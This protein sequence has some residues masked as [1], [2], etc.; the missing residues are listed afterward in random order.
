MRFWNRLLRV[1]KEVAINGKQK[2]TQNKKG[3]KNSVAGNRKRSRFEICEK[4]CENGESCLQ[5]FLYG[6]KTA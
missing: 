6:L 4:S 2:K 1:R 5:V 3:I